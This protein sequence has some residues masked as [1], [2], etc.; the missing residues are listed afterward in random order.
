M[1]R[2]ALTIDTDFFGREL[3]EWDWGHREDIPFMMN[4]IWAIRYGELDLLTETD[5][6]T[7]GDCP[8]SMLLFELAKKGLKFGRKTKLGVGW[9]HR[10]AHGFFQKL[11]FDILINIDAHH[12]AYTNKEEMDCGNWIFHL[13]NKRHFNYIW[14]R[15]KWLMDYKT[16][17]ND[18]HVT[19]SVASLA[20]L[21]IQGSVVGMYLAQSPA[22]LPPHHDEDLMDLVRASLMHCRRRKFDTDDGIANRSDYTVAKIRKFYQDYQ[23]TMKRFLAQKVVG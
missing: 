2:I 15:P 3:P 12:D 10:F 5:V 21:L 1:K 22:W 8:P 20:D 9:S 11:D 7:Y 4:G 14:V 17:L 16:T 6:E 23:E 19:C 18:C 13:D